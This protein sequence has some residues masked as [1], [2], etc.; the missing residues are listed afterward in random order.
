MYIYTKIE[1]KWSYP[2]HH[3]LINKKLDARN[4][5]SRFELLVRVI[6]ENPTHTF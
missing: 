3:K 5:L 4:G 1:F 6:A 2:R